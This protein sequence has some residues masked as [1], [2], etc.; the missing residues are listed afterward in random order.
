MVGVAVV[1]KNRGAG[2]GKVRGM[3]Q[4]EAVV[5][6]VAEDVCWKRRVVVMFGWEWVK[7][8]RREH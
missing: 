4:W 8:R 2:V 1:G 6:R 3:V 5:R 7:T